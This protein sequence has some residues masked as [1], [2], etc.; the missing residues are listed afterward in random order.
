M[1]FVDALIAGCDAI[2]KFHDN[3]YF[4]GEI[5][6]ARFAEKVSNIYKIWGAKLQ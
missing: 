2:I 6:S 3:V 5:V 1:Q 4:Y